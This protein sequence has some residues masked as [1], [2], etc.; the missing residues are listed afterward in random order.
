MAATASMIARSLARW[1]VV[2]HAVHTLSDRRRHERVFQ[3]RTYEPRGF[4]RLRAE[5]LHGQDHGHAIGHARNE[6][7]RLH[8]PAVN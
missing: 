4:R 6:C 5:T 8:R 3:R 7:V 1:V 2:L